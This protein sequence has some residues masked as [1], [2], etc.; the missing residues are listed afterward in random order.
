[1]DIKALKDIIRLNQ[2]AKLSLEEFEKKNLSQ[3]NSKL[4]KQH[5]ELI[6]LKNKT[7]LII[8]NNASDQSIDASDPDSAAQHIIGLAKSSAAFATCFDQISN[9]ENIGSVSVKDAQLAIQIKQSIAGWLGQH[10]GTDKEE[11]ENLLLFIYERAKELITAP[12]N[13]N[14]DQIRLILYAGKTAPC[15]K[16]KKMI[17]HFSNDNKGLIDVEIQHVKDSNND[18]HKVG[19]DNIPALLFKKGDKRIASHEGLISVSVLQKKINLLLNGGSLSDSTN[20]G[21]IKNLKQINKKELYNIGEYLLFYFVMPNCGVCKKTDDVV[22]RYGKNFSKVKFE[23][24]MVDGSHQLHRSFDVSHVPAVVFVRLGNII[25]RHTG[26]INPTNFE[27][28]MERF[29]RSTKTDMGESFGDEAMI[30]PSEKERISKEEQ[31]KMDDQ[32]K[33]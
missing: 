14:G 12:K 4:K 5:Q 13:M 28:M 29:T 11:T 8:E 16:M 10:S 23:K 27:E 25:G 33:N 30:I 7:D 1:M 9:M 31:E 15:K 21:S 22:E 32:F 18:I 17:H 6:T 19:I 3:Y 2:L 24:I 26:Y 20:I